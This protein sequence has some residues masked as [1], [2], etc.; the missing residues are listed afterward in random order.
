[1][2]ETK[3]SNLSVVQIVLLL[4]GALVAFQI[5]KTVVKGILVMVFNILLFAVFCYG[6]YRLYLHLKK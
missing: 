3:P 6:L 1:M 4:I 2:N 5:V